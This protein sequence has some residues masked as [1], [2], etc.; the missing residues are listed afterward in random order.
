MSR[1]T[2][3]AEELRNQRQCIRVSEELIHKLEEERIQIRAQEALRRQ[4]DRREKLIAAY[5]GYPPVDLLPKI[6]AEKGTSSII[7]EHELSYLEVEF[8]QDCCPGIRI[9]QSKCER[10]C[11]DDDD[12]EYWKL[13]LVPFK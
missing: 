2:E 10:Y 13:D 4:Q 3:I 12:D 8:L 9:T 5:D 7:I 6:D 11:G 1:I